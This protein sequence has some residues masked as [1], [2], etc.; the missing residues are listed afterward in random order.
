VNSPGESGLTLRQF[1]PVNAGGTV[2]PAFA[3]NTTSVEDG[4]RF[5]LANYFVPDLKLDAGQNYRAKSFLE[6]FGGAA[7]N[8][9]DLPLTTAAQMSAT[10]PYVSS[11]ARMP[12][13]VDRFVGSMHFVDGGYYG[14]RW[15][16]FG[17]RIP[18]LCA[19]AFEF[20]GCG[21]DR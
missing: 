21:D 8:F 9:A 5:L 1:S 18:A 13:D 17:D 2:S 3:M 7:P 20:K 6:T 14:Q 12:L 19:G 11:A 16:G 15:H 10:F 4:Q